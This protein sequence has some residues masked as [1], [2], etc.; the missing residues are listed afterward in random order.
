MEWTPLEDEYEAYC[1]QLEEAAIE[2]QLQD[3]DDAKKVGYPKKL[4]LTNLEKDQLTE[5]IA[6][7]TNEALEHFQAMGGVHPAIVG[8]S[9][10]N[11]AVAAMMWEYER[12]GR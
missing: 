8:Q 3:P 4:N 6:N 5:F 7:R 1:R 11:A 10:L 2:G 12:I 9:L